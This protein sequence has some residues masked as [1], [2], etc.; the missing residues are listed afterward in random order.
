[1]KL[2][3]PSTQPGIHTCCPFR[4]AARVWRVKTAKPDLDLKTHSVLCQPQ[5]PSL[6]NIKPVIIMT[7]KP[8]KLHKTSSA[9]RLLCAVSLL[10]S[11]R[12]TKLAGQYG[13]SSMR[14]IQFPGV[15]IISMAIV[16]ISIPHLSIWLFVHPTA[17]QVPSWTS[18]SRSVLR[19]LTSTFSNIGVDFTELVV[20]LI[21]GFFVS[22]ILLSRIASIAEQKPRPVVISTP[23]LNQSIPATFHTPRVTNPS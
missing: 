8:P 20:W 21:L 11:V 1:M 18:G 12:V 17:V 10:H 2:K 7:I 3:H 13:L 5:E 6:V 15:A 14:A 22:K 9:E 16:S 4:K 19:R 23:L